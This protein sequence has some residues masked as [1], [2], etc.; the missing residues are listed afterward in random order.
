MPDYDKRKKVPVSVI[1]PCYNCSETIN[2]TVESII[3][4]TRLP[5][6]LFLIN[7]ASPDNGRTIATLNSLKDRLG[8]IIDIHVINFTENKGPASARNAGWDAA[9]KPYI[10]FLDAD[11]RWHPQKL[12]IIYS[13]I[14]QNPQVDLIGHDF[15]LAVDQS[16]AR[17]VYSTQSIPG[18]IRK[19]FYSILLLNPFVT[20]S[21]LLKRDIRQIMNPHLRYCEDHEF[22]LRVSHTYNVY[23]L[24]LKLVQLGRE[25]FAEGGLT[26]KRLLMR[27][28]EIIMYLEAVK[29]RN[30]LS[31]FL[32]LLILL[33]MIK[34][35][36]LLGLSYFQRKTVKP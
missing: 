12:E 5:E 4:Q 24:K 6:E 31:L 20:P 29:Y 28:G 3:Q 16:S 23:Y 21:F 25:P 26:A 13:I 7:D 19:R 35:V 8:S 18:I 36:V 32:P 30:V 11:D 27:K 22:L 15:Y 17:T 2:L 1:I 34:H 9:T 10:S 14:E 33:S